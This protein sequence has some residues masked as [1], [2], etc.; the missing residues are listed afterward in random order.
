MLI[1][2]SLISTLLAANECHRGGS[3][4][5]LVRDH[6]DL[7]PI[8]T[9]RS[10]A[11]ALSKDSFVLYSKYA[12][13]EFLFHLKYSPD[14]PLYSVISLTLFNNAFFS[15]ALLQGRGGAWKHHKEERM[16]VR[17]T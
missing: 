3:I 10:K 5:W 14:I 2:M 1:V 12:E 9:R 4:A 11:G 7:D 13:I 8:Y 16:E 15:P 6:A 17:H